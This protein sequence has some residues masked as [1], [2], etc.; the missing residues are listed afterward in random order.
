MKR[1]KPNTLEKCA[2]LLLGSFETSDERRFSTRRIR[3]E[4]VIERTFC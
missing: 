1:R 3:N 4:E 2:G